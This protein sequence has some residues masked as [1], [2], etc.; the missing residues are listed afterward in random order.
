M[1]Y[2]KVKRGRVTDSVLDTQR[3]YHQDKIMV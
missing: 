1:L 3:G 2:C